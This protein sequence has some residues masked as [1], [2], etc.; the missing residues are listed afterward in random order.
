MLWRIF[1]RH[2][3]RKLP[4]IT[5]EYYET[6]IPLQ[7]D[8]VKKMKN[9]TRIERSIRRK[10]GIIV[11]LGS[12]MQ[13]MCREY[14]S[15]VEMLMARGTPRFTEISQELYGSSE[16]AFH[17]GG[18]HAERSAELVTGTLANIKD[19]VKTQADEKKYTSE[20]TVAILAHSLGEYFAIQTVPRA[21]CL[22]MGFWRMQ[23][24]AQIV[25]VLERTVCSASVKSGRLKFMKAG[26]IL[27][28]HL[29]GM[30]QPVCTFLSKGPPSSTVTQEGWRLLPKYLLFH[31]GPA[32]AAF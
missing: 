21:L 19:Q 1:F 22:G 7:F 15:V 23:Q 8:P 30:L 16:D 31:H 11:A 9:F 14:C 27:G 3:G 29:N 13:R 24:Q 12:I 4:H 26:C 5:T 28:R 2:K 17:I 25:F 18:A 20:E 10:L 6:K 32:G